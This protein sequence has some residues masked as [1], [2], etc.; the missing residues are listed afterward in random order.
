MAAND[1]T[2]EDVERAI[3]QIG[4]RAPEEAIPGLTLLANRAIIE[5]H[6]VS[7]EQANQRR[8]QPD[9]GKWARLANAIRSGVLQVAAIRDS[10]KGLELTASPTSAGA[11]AEP[12]EAT[13]DEG[14]M[15]TGDRS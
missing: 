8:G 6:R 4:A 1:P 15:I 5:L 11:S 10:V 2:P 13:H 12:D 3:R 9:W 14:E 7:R